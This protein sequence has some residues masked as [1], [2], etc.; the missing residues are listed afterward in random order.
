MLGDIEWRALAE[1]Y[2]LLLSQQWREELASAAA[3]EYREPDC[4]WWL[5]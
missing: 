3:K 5:R 2:L 1:Q 4:V